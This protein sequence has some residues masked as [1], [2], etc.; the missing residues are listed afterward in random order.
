MRSASQI[1]V[2][3]E[4][5]RGDML[6]R[7]EP[8]ARFPER[9]HTIYNSCPPPAAS[10]CRDRREGRTESLFRLV[11]AGSIYGGREEMLHALLKALAAREASSNKEKVT[12]EY[13]GHSADA[14]QA[15]VRATGIWGAKVCRAVSHD[16]LM[17]RLAM[18]DS[19]VVLG[20]RSHAYSLPA[21][22]FE[23]IS[24]RRPILAVTPQGE[25]AS[26]ITRMNVGVAVHGDDPATICEA[27]DTLVANSGRYTQALD[28]AARTFSVYGMARKYCSVLESAT[29]VAGLQSVSQRI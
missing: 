7:P 8:W 13:Y 19:L 11:Y 2:V 1:V 16:E 5:M 12:F 27:I 9:L 14:C 23:Y 4:T 29:G 10:S 20:S 3:T 18:A 24:M 21:K 28:E 15:L 22:V 26:F 6:Q 17:L 25:L